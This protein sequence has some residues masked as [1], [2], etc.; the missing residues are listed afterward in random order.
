MQPIE[1][2]LVT[3][4][5]FNIQISLH[6]ETFEFDEAYGN[7]E[8]PK[9]I[10]SN[11]TIKLSTE[12][13]SIQN[14]WSEKKPGPILFKLKHKR[15]QTNPNSGNCGDN[16]K[17]CF[18]GNENNENKGDN[19]NEGVGQMV[20]DFDDILGIS[21]SVKLAIGWSETCE[22]D[23]YLRGIRKAVLLVKYSN[24]VKH[25]IDVTSRQQKISQQDCQNLTLL[26]NHYKT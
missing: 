21:H 7:P 6:S 22:E 26:I 5:A 3:P 25:L 1:R 15:N 10:S 4:I 24:F 23:I 17:N 13:P 11:S 9:S 16:E 12:F 20:V 14:Q 8:I 19:D 18:G 2:Y